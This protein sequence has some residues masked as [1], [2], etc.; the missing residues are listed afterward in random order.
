M[1]LQWYYNGIT[2]AANRCREIEGGNSMKIWKEGEGKLEGWRGEV[3][4]LERG[5]LGVEVGIVG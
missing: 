4:G 5:S 1:V 3:R 2:L